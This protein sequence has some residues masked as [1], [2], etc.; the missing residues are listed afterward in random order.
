MTGKSAEILLIYA[1]VNVSIVAPLILMSKRDIL[2][3]VIFCISY[4]FAV[5]SFVALQGSNPGYV[6]LEGIIDI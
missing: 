1:A 2:H 3:S 4:V 5:I 6:R